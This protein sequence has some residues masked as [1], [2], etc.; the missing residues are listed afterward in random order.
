MLVPAAWRAWRRG[1]LGPTRA[2]YVPLVIAVDLPR[3]AARRGSRRPPPRSPT[4]PRRSSP[5]RW[6]W[7]SRAWLAPRIQTFAALVVPGAGAADPRRHPDRQRPG[8]AA[9]ARPLPRRRR[10][11]L[12]R[13]R[14][15]GRR[16]SGRAPTCPR[17]PGWPPTRRSPGC[18]RTSAP[19]TTITQPAG[20]DSMTPLFIAH[21]V[22]EEVLR[23]IL[24]N[25]VDFIVVDTR[26]G[27]PDRAVRRASS[28]AAPATGRTP[29]TIKR[30][31]VE[32][33]EDQPG[34]DLVL[35]GPGQ[36]LRRAPAAARDAD[37]R[38]TATR[39]ASPAAGRRGRCSP[40]GCCC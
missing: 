1:S 15:G 4:A 13:L 5:W 7:S 16:R 10:A 29:Q 24:H 3:A 34:F 19:V 25:D 26:H 32:K 6:R 21:S 36:G 11:A 14:D 28:R 37:V 2:R 9:G 39:P 17:A 20:F 8:L 40:P 38:A 22:D 23:L 12:D 35:D 30:D 18:C 33:F 31:Q 27:R